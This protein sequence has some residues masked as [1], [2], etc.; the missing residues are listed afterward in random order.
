MGVQRGP[1]I[2]YHIHEGTFKEVL[3]AQA[4]RPTS[5]QGDR[6]VDPEDVVPD[7]FHLVPIAEKRFGG[8]W[9][10]LSRLVAIDEVPPVKPAPVVHSP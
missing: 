4:L 9:A 8:R 1:Q 10:R 2:A 5:A 6:G 3:V 7:G